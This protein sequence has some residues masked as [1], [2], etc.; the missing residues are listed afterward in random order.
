MGCR[1]KKTM[2]FMA[3]AKEAIIIA[4]PCHRLRMYFVCVQNVV[5]PPRVWE[6][7]RGDGQGETRLVAACSSSRTISI[8]LFIIHTFR[9]LFFL[10]S[11]ASVAKIPLPSWRKRIHPF[12]KK[13]K[14]ECFLLR[15]TVETGCWRS[16]YYIYVYY[17]SLPFMSSPSRNNDDGIAV[18]ETN[19]NN[20]NRVRS[21]E[22]TAP[23]QAFVAI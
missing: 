8:S 18:F 19:M 16:R 17:R 15:A 4:K 1:G 20:K 22:A 6:R 23:K 10:R 7:Q 21:R 5:L 3:P 2:P 14:L 11:P 9:A 12:S 13:K